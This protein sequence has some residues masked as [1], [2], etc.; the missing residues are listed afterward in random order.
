MGN[1]DNDLSTP[2]YK[3]QLEGGF[4]ECLIGKSWSIETWGGWNQMM[5]QYRA[6]LANTRAPHDVIFQTCSDTINPALMR[7]GL[8][9]ALLEDGYAAFTQNSVMTPPLFDE[10]SAPLG[11]PSEAPPV[12]AT[13]SGIWL[14]H[15]SNGLVL[16][17]P[18]TQTLSVNIGNGYRHLSG[19]QD[20][21]VNNGS[22]ES[23]VTMPAR[24]GL[25]MIKQ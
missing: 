14:R 6:V 10:Y 13:S 21:T 25:L 4:L 5:A 15:Y 11:T 2:E 22:A 8:A 3:G 7:Y 18:T 9:S 19:S 23:V 20:P 16:V 12:A 17:N 24:S 1:T